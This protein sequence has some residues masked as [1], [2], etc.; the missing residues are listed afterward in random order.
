MRYTPSQLRDIV[1]ISQETLRHWRATL[2]PL[3]GVRGHG[4]SFKPGQV[5]ATAAVKAM[6]E[7]CGVSVRSL[8]G[9]ASALFEVC[10]HPDWEVFSHGRLVLQL[11]P[12]SVRLLSEGEQ[13]PSESILILISLAPIVA[14]LRRK[15]LNVTREEDQVALHFSPVPVAKNRAAMPSRRRS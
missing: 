9:V 1:G 11:Q 5:L 13:V 2:A 12:G 7:E 15:L 4:P 3:Q 8:T 6:V 10:E 14:N